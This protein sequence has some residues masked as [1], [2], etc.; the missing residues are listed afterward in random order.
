M[1]RDSHPALNQSARC[2]MDRTPIVVLLGSLLWGLLLP[3]ARA[4]AAP[5]LQ[6]QS[7][8][9]ET[10]ISWSG[11]TAGALFQ[12]EATTGL[13]PADWQPR[14]GTAFWPSVRTQWVEALPA[15]GASFFR[16][17]ELDALPRGALVT[18]QWVRS[19]TTPELTQL[20]ALLGLTNIAPQPVE[21]WKMVYSTINA[22]GEPTRASALAVIPSESGSA[23]PMASYQHG[24]VLLREDVPSRLNTE[25]SLGLI[26]G[27]TGYAAVLPDYVGLGDSPGFHP[28]HHAKSEATAVVDGL[29][30][31][32][33]FLSRVSLTWNGQLFLTG[34][35]Q[36][37]H[38]TLAAQREIEQFHAV[39]FE[40][41]ASAPAAGAYDLAGTALPDFLSGRA[42]PNP[43]YLPYFLK[44]YI[45]VYGW[46]PDL[47]AVLRPPWNTNLPPLLDGAHDGGQLNAVLPADPL[48]ILESSALQSLRE[49]PNDPLRLALRDNGLVE[50]WSPH[51]PTRLYHCLADQDVLFA[52][53]QVAYDAFRA[54]GSTNL[55][56]VDPF[57]PGTHGTCVPFALLSAKEWFD[58]LRR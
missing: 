53:S 40:I 1:K 29:R 17:V 16:V 8:A 41:T 3:T 2:I 14:G 21:A 13:S 27:A 45:D 11:G 43:Y 34:Y 31:M 30:A 5:F 4:T 49:N 36:G 57:P 39:E 10:R 47:A 7:T 6:I 35:S 37:G 20:F 32:R 44:A 26:L 50:G 19:F 33:E 46:A 38:A 9:G 56:L 51:S 52:N 54:A 18:N 28:Y 24:T 42:Q 55:A 48:Q 25:G 15:S 23:L 22:Q 12:L 58:S